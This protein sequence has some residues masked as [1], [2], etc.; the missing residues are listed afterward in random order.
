VVYLLRDTTADVS[1]KLKP[2]VVNAAHAAGLE[3]F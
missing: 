3:P 1:P 2:L